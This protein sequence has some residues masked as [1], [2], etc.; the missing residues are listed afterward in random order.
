[1]SYLDDLV[2]IQNDA[3]DNLYDINIT[4]PTEVQ[5]GVSTLNLKLRAGDV[6]IPQ[7]KVEPYKIN[8]K[9]I[10]IE[11]PKP[12]VTLARKLTIP[13]RIDADYELYKSLLSWQELVFSSKGNYTPLDSGKYGK[14]VVATYNSAQGA[15]DGVQNRAAKITF[16][17]VW[18]AGFNDGIQL[19]REG[20]EALKL[21]AEFNFIDMSTV[22]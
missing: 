7:A 16:D 6:S 12:K 14:I 3:F 13:F 15:L 20:G 2:A 4:L 1:M 17:Y 11:K 18:F 9:T 10:E 8:Y 22:L 19:K 21:T 5:S